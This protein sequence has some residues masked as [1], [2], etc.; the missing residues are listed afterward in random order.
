MCLLL[1][2]LSGGFI[3]AWPVCN[4]GIGPKFGP[5]KGNPTKIKYDFE[6]YGKMHR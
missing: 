3:Q 6:Y 5:I 1:Y 4:L 2:K